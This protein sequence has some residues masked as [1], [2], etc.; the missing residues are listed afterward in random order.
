MG[1]T[2]QKP[3]DEDQNGDDRHNAPGGKEEQKHPR[4]VAWQAG[5]GTDSKETGAWNEARSCRHREPGHPDQNDEWQAQKYYRGNH[6][7]R[8]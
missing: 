7:R 4:R 6:E 8:L 2:P 3:G 5:A 1:R